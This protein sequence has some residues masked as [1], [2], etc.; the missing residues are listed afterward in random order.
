MN[1]SVHPRELL[2]IC[3]RIG[4]IPTKHPSFTFLDKLLIIT[5]GN[6]CTMRASNMTL[7][8]EC[9]TFATVDEPGKV[10]VDPVQLQNALSGIPETVSAVHLYTT[11]NELFVKALGIEISLPTYHHEDFPVLPIVEGQLVGAVSGS[12][13][14][15]A[16]KKV[17]FAASHSD[18]KPELSAVYVQ[19]GSGQLVTVATDGFRL[20]EYTDTFD[21]KSEHQFLV[22]AKYVG[23]IA[24][25]VD[26]DS[27]IE[28]RIDGTLASI[29]SAQM[30]MVIRLV[31]GNYP[32]YR[33]IIPKE[34]ITTVTALKDDVLRSCRVVSGFTDQF[35]K[36]DVTVNVATAELTIH[37]PRSEK[38]SGLVTI[39]AAVTGEDV[40]IRMSA[41]N[42]LDALTIIDDTSVAIT[43]NGSSKPVIATGFHS[44]KSV[45]LMMPMGR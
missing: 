29:T 13:F 7:A 5:E 1:T 27:L 22:A 38:G 40:T 8:V 19:I 41:K 4:K 12:V 6:T 39:P 42:I 45:I 35:T 30:T 18:I 21:T 36:I 33:Q 11:G 24:R 37:A 26:G 23:D 44:H 28:I 34:S 3:N 43:F 20:A 16:I 2:E 32:D 25:L 9:S 14:S 17:S 10:L 15:Q 31:S